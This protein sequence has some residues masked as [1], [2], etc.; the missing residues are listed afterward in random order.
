M[1]NKVLEGKSVLM[2]IAAKDFRDEELAEPRA[3]LAEAGAAITI[4]S[5]A[6]RESV[7]VLKRTRVTPDLTVDQ[8]DAKAYDAVIF[9]GGPG[10]SQYWHDET[11][12]RI[13]TEAYEAG[14][15]VGA[16]C[17][18]PATL[19]NAGLLKGKKATAFSSITDQLTKGGANY[20]GARVQQDGRIVTA[21][22]PGSATT[23]GEA[24]RDALSG[25]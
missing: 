11:A 7:G 6:T 5:S 24:I 12:H 17:I 8:V 10:A 4:A 19:A 9:V 2:I 22:G 13:A 15:V 18:A 3:V 20:T 1:G 21:D 25:Q 16:I 23:F 14:K